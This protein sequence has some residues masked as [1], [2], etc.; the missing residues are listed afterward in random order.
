MT[1]KTHQQPPQSQAPPVRVY[2]TDGRIMVAAPLPG[3]EPPDISITVSGDRVMIRG[4]LRGPHQEECDL[5][6]SEWAVGPYYRELTLPLPVN[7]ALTNA[8]YGNGVLVL[9]MPKLQPGHQ[10]SNAT[11]QLSVTQ[12]P[13]GGRIGHTGRERRET[14]TEAHRQRMEQSAR[15]AAQGAGNRLMQEPPPS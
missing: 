14:T 1:A 8:T 11:F 9:A 6:P 5:L 15:N 13:R 10:V 2:Q 7:G 4:Q 12:A 3:L